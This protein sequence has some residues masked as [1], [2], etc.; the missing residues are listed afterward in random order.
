MQIQPN[1]QV[2]DTGHSQVVVVSLS[3]YQAP[4]QMS[5]FKS[6]SSSCSLF[7]FPGIS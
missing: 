3:P 1:I 7:H 2:S 4:A 5:R 6:H